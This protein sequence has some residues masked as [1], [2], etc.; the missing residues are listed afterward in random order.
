MHLCIEQDQVWLS[1]QN[2]DIYTCIHLYQ[3]IHNER[4]EKYQEF[5]VVTSSC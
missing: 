5:D 1:I 2:L 4:E 3:L